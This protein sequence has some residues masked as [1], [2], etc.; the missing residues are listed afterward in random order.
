[1]LTDR[2]QKLKEDSDA[3]RADLKN[4]L[5]L[6]FVGGLVNGGMPVTSRGYDI[7]YTATK[8]AANDIYRRPNVSDVAPCSM[9][10]LN[11][12]IL[13]PSLVDVLTG[14]NGNAVVLDGYRAFSIP[15]PTAQRQS[16]APVS[17]LFWPKP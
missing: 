14:R 3:G 9:V 15:R 12:D 2:G 17:V 8:D 16:R 10:T 13:P 6:Y 7:P 1:M 5:P 11:A 4:R